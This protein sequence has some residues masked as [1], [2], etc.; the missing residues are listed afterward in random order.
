MSRAPDNP[1]GVGQLIWRLIWSFIRWLSHLIRGEVVRRVGGPARARVIVLFAAVL[2]LNGADTATV[3]AV[4]PQLES[5]LRIGDAKIGLLSAVSLLVGA[6]FTIPVGLFV[7]RAR[8][9]PLLALSIVLW[10][11]ASLTSA[12]AGSYS[13]LLLTRLALGA[14]AATAGPAIASLTGDYFPAKERGRV[15]AYILGGEVAGTAVGFIVSGSVASLIDWRVAFVILAVPGFFL[16]RELWRTVPEPLRGGQSRLEPGV[17]DLGQA[18]DAA[19][20]R[21]SAQSTDASQEPE[22]IHEDELAQKAAEAQGAR[23]NPKLVLSEDPQHMGLVPAIKYL[24]RIPSNVLMIIGSSLGYFFFSGLQTFALKFVVSHYKVGQATAELALALLVGGALVGTLASG[25]IT[26]MMLRR[27]NLSARVVVPAACYVGAAVLL[28]PG[29]ISSSLTPALWFDVAGAALISAA[30]PPLQA[31]RLDIVPA[32]LWGRAESVRTFVRSIA[33]GVAPLLFGGVSGLV[34]GFAVHQAPI[35]TKHV[36]HSSTPSGTGLGLEV[37]F[38]VML[39]SLVAAGVVLYR[40]RAS[41]P[42]DVATAA[43]SRQA[44]RPPA[45]TEPEPGPPPRTSE[46]DGAPTQAYPVAPRERGGWPRRPGEDP[47]PPG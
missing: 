7:D 30:N 17:L 20:R 11:L 28:I 32:G 37:A 13:G 1:P 44:A 36:F 39:V 9:M 45:P 15:Y 27:G 35:G 24:L 21:A 43:A 41:Y 3:G 42:S 23:P 46:P 34:A 16:A 6:V 4:A 25:R 29:F 19:R 10:S 22:E 33:Q 2:A 5:A 12:F 31:A 8:R 40:A 18:V 47:N 38:L 26:D 14:V